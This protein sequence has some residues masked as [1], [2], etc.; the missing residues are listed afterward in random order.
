[1]IF[2]FRSS[3]RHPRKDGPSLVCWPLVET[4][5]GRESR[6]HCEQDY[7]RWTCV[8]Y[9]NLFQHVPAVIQA[10][11]FTPCRR[12][13]FDWLQYISSLKSD[14]ITS[15]SAPKQQRRYSTRLDLFSVRSDIQG[16]MD[17]HGSAD[18]WWKLRMAGKV[19]ITANIY[20]QKNLFLLIPI[21]IP[22]FPQLGR[23]HEW[24]PVDFIL[25]S[26]EMTH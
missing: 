15:V 1:M 5:N 2:I 24:T 7:Y 13:I 19:V 6:H 20:H 26:H 25:K 3:L 16:R 12:F 18:L 11:S 4:T 10:L 14:E 22:S 9:N 17:R 21:N 23:N 8:S